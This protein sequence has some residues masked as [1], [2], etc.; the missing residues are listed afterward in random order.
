MAVVEGKWFSPNIS[1]YDPFETRDLLEKYN[2]KASC[3]DA[4]YPLWSYRCVEHIEDG[5]FIRRTDD[6]A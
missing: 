5:D 2:L 4:H 6:F 1:M 3:L